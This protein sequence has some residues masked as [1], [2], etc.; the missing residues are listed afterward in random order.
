MRFSPMISLIDELTFYA[1]HNA[2]YDRGFKFIVQ[3]CSEWTDN[4]WVPP[5]LEGASEWARSLS[6]KVN[7]TAI[8]GQTVRLPNKFYQFGKSN[9]FYSNIAD[10]LVISLPL[11]LCLF[12]LLRGLH[13][14]LARLGLL[15]FLQALVR[16]FSSL[17]CFWG[18]TFADN[19]TFLGFH[20]FLQFYA[21]VPYSDGAH[22]FPSCV[23][24]LLTLFAALLT[25]CFLGFAAWRFARSVFEISYFSADDCRSYLFF[26]L[27]LAVKCLSAFFHAY[28][29]SAQDRAFGLFVLQTFLLL[30]LVCC[31]G[32]I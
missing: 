22:S 14:L 20:C 12:L 7:E 9:N 3:L 23:L 29:D 5:F 26:G 30:A 11:N 1:Y 18:A 31:C 15:P 6:A 10:F 28:V 17:A 2:N 4:K 21:F 24:C 19:L 8:D 25:V 16:P 13:A 27:S 32:A